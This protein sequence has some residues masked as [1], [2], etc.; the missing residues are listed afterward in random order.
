MDS[1]E[2]ETNDI[3]LIIG[4]N[5]GFTGMLSDGT[6]Y[7]GIAF[8]D[9]KYYNLYTGSSYTGHALTETKNWY[10]DYADFVGSAFPWFVRGGV[11][12]N[13]S[14]AGVFGFSRDIGNSNFLN[15][16]G[17]SLSDNSSRIVIS[18]KL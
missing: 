4:S 1:S 9:S 8:P 12:Y 17:D 10:S 14:S 13:S 16:S 7:T 6:T 2:R 11:Y 15:S 3:L 5:S 18:N